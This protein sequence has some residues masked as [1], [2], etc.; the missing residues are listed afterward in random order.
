MS[1]RILSGTPYKRNPDPNVNNGSASPEGLYPW[2]V[3]RAQLCAIAGGQVSS[4]S[5]VDNTTRD[6]LL[7]TADLPAIGILLATVTTAQILNPT[8]NVLTFVSAAP[9]LA[10]SSGGLTSPAAADFGQVL[11]GYSGNG[12]L[13][14][15]VSGFAVRATQAQTPSGTTTSDTCLLVWTNSA[16]L[17]SPVGPSLFASADAGTASRVASPTP[18]ILEVDSYTAAIRNNNNLYTDT[19][20]GVLYQVVGLWQIPT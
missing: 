11:S 2:S 5:L 19:V 9:I 10:T 3:F 12:R 16:I 17:N 18:I 6:F 14:P 20:S 4:S 13:V 15:D 1:I 7:F 8:R